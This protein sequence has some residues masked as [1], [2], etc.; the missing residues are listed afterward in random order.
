MIDKN[1]IYRVE[2][3]SSVENDHH[4]KL[5]N[6]LGREGWILV[7]TVYKPPSRYSDG[8]FYFYFKKDNV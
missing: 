2:S 7:S 6:D 8:K 1:F 5:L 3:S 4:D